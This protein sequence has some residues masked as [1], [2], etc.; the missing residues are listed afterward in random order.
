MQE[1]IVL[2]EYRVQDLEALC[3]LDESCFAPEFRFD[4][5]TMRRF[6]GYRQ[7][8]VVVAED[9]AGICGFVIVHIEGSGV[10][11]GGYV[12][13]LDVA[14]RSR[15]SGLA[16]R[17]MEEATVQARSAG[18][19]WMGLHVFAENDG[20]IA[21]YERAG[22]VRGELIPGFY[23]TSASGS[24]MDAWVYRRWIGSVKEAEPAS[25]EAPL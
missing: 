2:R 23:G 12:V 6:V 8:I 19:V 1:N 18:G 17:L 5:E 22:Y 14:E 25:V 13:T 9:D 4:R 16:G 20:A 24:E 3:R 15:R 10:A 21:F 11:L 7:A